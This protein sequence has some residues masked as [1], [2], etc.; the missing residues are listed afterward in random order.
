MEVP[1]GSRYHVIVLDTVKIT[2]DFDIEST[3][4]TG[5]IV[6]NVGRAL[7]KKKMLLLRSK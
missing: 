1:N 2:F 4:K 7:L 6:N 3:D 5:S